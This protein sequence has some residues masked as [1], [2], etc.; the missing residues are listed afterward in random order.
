MVADQKIDP[1]SFSPDIDEI[2]A[3]FKQMPPR[4]AA[5]H[6]G[7][8]IRRA[9]EPAYKLLKDKVRAKHKGPTG[10]LLRA[11]RVVVRKYTRAGTAVG[12]V[13]FQAAGKGPKKSAQGGKVQKG[14]DRAYHAGF[15][16]FG[17]KPRRT[18]KNIASSYRTLGPFTISR[19]KQG[20]QKGQMK[21][22]PGYPKA[23]FKKASGDSGVSTGKGEAY[24]PVLKTYRQSMTRLRAKMVKEL[25]ESIQKASADAIGRLARNIPVR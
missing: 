7:A 20:K 22:K 11:V 15:I 25:S 18:K 16:E 8:G 10:N 14:G 1:V 17:T 9:I 24:A 5:I 21:T 2:I 13:G 23:F 19:G 3:A 4:L 6:M 12:L